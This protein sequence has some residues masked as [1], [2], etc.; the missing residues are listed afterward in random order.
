MEWMIPQAKIRKKSEK[1]Q[2]K[3]AKIIKDLL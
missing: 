2:K 1:N 3:S